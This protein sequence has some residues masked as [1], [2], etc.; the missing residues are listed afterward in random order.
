MAG[1]DELE[2]ASLVAAPVVAATAKICSGWDGGGVKDGHVDG[3]V[4]LARFVWLDRREMGK[5]WE[6]VYVSGF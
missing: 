4:L 3:L 6:C 5:L 2:S 1:I